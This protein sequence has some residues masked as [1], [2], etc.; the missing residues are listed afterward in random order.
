MVLVVNDITQR[1]LDEERIR[2]Q[3]TYDSLT[4]LP[5]RVLFHD[6]LGQAVRTMHRNGLPMALMFI[7]LDGFK[8]VNDTLGHD[9]GDLLLKE[10]ARRLASCVRESDTVARLG[11]DEFTVIMAGI[12]ETACVHDVAS[13]ILRSLSVPFEL[14]THEGRPQVGAVSASIGVALAPEHADD[15]ETLLRLADSAM[16]RAKDQGKSRYVICEAAAHT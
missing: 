10:A 5:N 11:G 8:A 1:K 9:A 2:Y 14:G 7:D 13:R 4:G 3:A 16:Y 12:E 15:A 6:R